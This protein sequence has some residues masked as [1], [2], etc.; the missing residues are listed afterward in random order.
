M[1]SRPSGSDYEETAIGVGASWGIA[2]TD[3]EG[4]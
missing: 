4:S 1:P 2:D 3:K